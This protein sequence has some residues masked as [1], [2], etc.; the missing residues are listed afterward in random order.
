MV[1]ADG[2]AA[3]FPD[4]PG[5]GA[6]LCV[7]RAA[8]CRALAVSSALR[9]AARAAS[10]FSG[11]LFAIR[12][13][14]LPAL[15]RTPSPSRP[16][17]RW[18]LASSKSAPSPPRRSR[19]IRARASFVIRSSGALINR[20]GFNNDGADAIAQR[21]RRLRASARRP[22]IP[23]GINLGKSKVTPL[24]EAAARLSLLLSAT[25][26][27]S[28]ITSR[29]TSARRTRPGLRS[30]QERDA[31]VEL[32][33]TI[34]EENARLPAPKPILLKIAPDL[35]D[36]AMEE[37]ISGVLRNLRLAGIIATNT[38]LDHSAIAPG[39]DETGG[40]S[41]GPL[42]A[43]RDRGR[44]ISARADALCRLSAWAEFPTRVG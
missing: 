41:G 24:E 21:L 4:G 26:R 23:I 11:C 1:R 27:A 35:S 43:A 37:I 19:E 16:G 9:A 17:R 3:P 12:S 42:R 10:S 34:T 40:L 22:S 39:E 5:D 32:L 8:T 44:E 15:T 18:V 13:A 14:S 36:E 38:T 29:S 33:R 6:S 25:A 30:L 28:P 7:G 20:L 31:L 2:A